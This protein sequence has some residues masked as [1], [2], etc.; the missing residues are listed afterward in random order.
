MQSSAAKT[1]LE[2]RILTSSSQVLLA[3]TTDVSANLASPSQMEAMLQL[4]VPMTVIV[5]A[6]LPVTTE[7]S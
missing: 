4:A 2:V 3:V 5:Y 1:D 6:V 7:T